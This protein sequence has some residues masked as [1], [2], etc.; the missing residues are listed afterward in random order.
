M[1]TFCIHSRSFDETLQLST[2]QGIRLETVVA[3]TIVPQIDEDLETPPDMST[4]PMW[5][6]LLHND[7]VTPMEYVLLILE[8]LFFLSS[9]LAEHVMWT[10]HTEGTAVVVLRPRNEADRLIKA[11]HGRARMDGFP[12]T[13][14][15]EPD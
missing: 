4:E 10:A 8:H 15:M 2:I 9:E 7:N 12:L 3:P 13:F 11:A 1:P 14:S 5:R 6:V